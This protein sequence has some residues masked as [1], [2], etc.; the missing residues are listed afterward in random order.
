MTVELLYLP[1]RRENMELTVHLSFVLVLDLLH[2]S[3][4][5]VSGTG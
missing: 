2:D 3:R 5:T 4:L 1:W